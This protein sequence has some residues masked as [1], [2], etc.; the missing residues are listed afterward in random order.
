MGLSCS[1]SCAGRDHLS[2]LIESPGCR[3]GGQCAAQWVRQTRTLD[4]EDLVEFVSGASHGWQK[5]KTSIYRKSRTV[6]AT[7]FVAR[8]FGSNLGLAVSFVCVRMSQE[9]QIELFH[10]R[11]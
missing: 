8:V 10:A 11:A 6:F 3:A 7:N 4:E 5:Q 9:A 1:E 2:A